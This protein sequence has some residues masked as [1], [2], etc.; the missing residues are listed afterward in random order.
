MARRKQLRATR[1]AEKAHS[2]SRL[3]LPT[4]KKTDPNGSA[5]GYLEARL[6]MDLLDAPLSATDWRPDALSLKLAGMSPRGLKGE[7]KFPAK[8]EDKFRPYQTEIG[9]QEELRK[10]NLSTQI[11]ILPSSMFENQRSWL[12]VRRWNEPP[13]LKQAK[14]RQKSEK[15]LTWLQFSQYYETAEAN[16]RNKLRRKKAVTPKPIKQRRHPASVSSPRTQTM[17]VPRVVHCS[18]QKPASEG[19]L[20]RVRRLKEEILRS[21]E[22]KR[23]DSEATLQLKA[24]KHLKKSLLRLPICLKH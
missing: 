15:S 18:S 10:G 14:A 2:F 8:T 19:K 9:L 13:I 20:A 16:F 6:S 4:K 11:E 12:R 1:L 22:L 5:S 7:A 24:V 17:K 21:E 3:T 23:S